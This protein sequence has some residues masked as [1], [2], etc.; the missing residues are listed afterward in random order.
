MA[1]T[2]QKDTRYDRVLG[3]GPTTK[4]TGL[5]NLF[6]RYET[7]LTA[8]QYMSFAYM[9][10]PYMGVGRNLMYKKNLFDSINGYD[11][12]ENIASGDDDLFVKNAATSLN[13]AINLDQNSF[14]YSEAKSTFYSFLHQ[15]SRHISTSV[16]YNFKHQILLTLFALSQ[17]SFWL[18]LSFGILFL[19]LSPWVLITIMVIKWVCQMFFHHKAMSILKE[20][21][22]NKWFPLMDIMM[23]LYY[24][25]L[26]IVILFRRN[27]W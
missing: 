16:H 25:I 24:I 27:S 18:S 20:N 13:T 22:L 1:T 6:A 2:L 15:K 21:D 3:Y 8:Y 11:K 19:G 14:M 26:P 7:F 4:T 17:I 12:H 9:K 23:F 5:L 10:F